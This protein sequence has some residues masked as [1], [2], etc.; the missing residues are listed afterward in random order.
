MLKS[1]LARWCSCLSASRSMGLRGGVG[2]GRQSS[3]ASRRDRAGFASLPLA[4][5]SPARVAPHVPSAIVSPLRRYPTAL[6][7]PTAPIFFLLQESLSFPEGIF[8]ERQSTPKQGRWWRR[9]E[10]HLFVDAGGVTWSGALWT[11][12]G[13]SG[14]GAGREG[15]G[16]PDRVTPPAPKRVALGSPSS[17]VPAYSSTPPKKTRAA[18]K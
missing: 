6:T 2:A 4:P 11:S 13:R 3:G 1:R 18:E 15:T 9:T 10:R 12:D 5:P 17:L 8:V 7:A 14:S 16:A